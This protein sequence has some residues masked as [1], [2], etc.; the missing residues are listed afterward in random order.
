MTPR[1]KARHEITIPRKD[2]IQDCMG[3]LSIEGLKKNKNEEGQ[4]YFK[5]EDFE[6]GFKRVTQN[7]R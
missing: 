6:E 4:E 5:K 7:A 1:V 3:S 2:I